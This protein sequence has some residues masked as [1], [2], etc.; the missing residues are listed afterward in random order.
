MFNNCPR[1]FFHTQKFRRKYFFNSK[2]AGAGKIPPFSLVSTQRTTPFWPFAILQMWQILTNVALASDVHQTPQSRDICIIWDLTATGQTHFQV[3]PE[4]N[5]L[6][7]GSPLERGS[8]LLASWG[9]C[10]TGV[11]FILFPESLVHLQNIFSCIH[12]YLW[13]KTEFTSSRT[14]PFLFFCYLYLRGPNYK[15]APYK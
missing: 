2:K 6:L 5:L 10:S 1:V 3:W 11:V 13:V 4:R 9:R 15:P 7:G 8:W 12:S 14:S